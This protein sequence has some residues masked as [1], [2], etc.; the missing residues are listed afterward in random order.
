MTNW[1]KKW[2]DLIEDL[3]MEHNMPPIEVRFDL[4]GQ[5]AGYGG[6]DF[7]PGSRFGVVSAKRKIRNTRHTLVEVAEHGQWNVELW[8]RLN[9]DMVKNEGENFYET[10]VHE[11]AHCYV[12]WNYGTNVYPHGTEWFGAM[13]HLGFKNPKV[14]HNYK[15]TKSKQYRHFMYECECVGEE[16][17]EFPDGTTKYT[18]SWALTA[19]RHNKVLKGHWYNCPKCNTRL[20]FIREIG[21]W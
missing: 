13:E 6:G 19:V 11:F 1:K 10:V 20:K 15:T 4:K 5:T 21:K 8:I 18:Y 7:V 16:V 9:E 17:T 2:T 14:T 3:R 12:L